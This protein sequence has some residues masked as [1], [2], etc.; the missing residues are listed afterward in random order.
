[1]TEILMVILTPQ[2]KKAMRKRASHASSVREPGVD[3]RKF[4]DNLE[5]RKT[6]MKLQLQYVNSIHTTTSLINNIQDSD[7]SLAEKITLSLNIYEK[8]V[9]FKE[10][11]SFK[12]L[13]YYWNGHIIAQCRQNNKINQI[14]HRNT[15]NQ[16]NHFTD[17]LKK[18]EVY[19][20]KTFK[21][22]ITQKKTFLSNSSNSR[23]QTPYSNIFPE[24]SP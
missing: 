2:L 23:P 24:Q 16:I 7:K 1:M 4:L 21:A 10:K 22:I 3:F 11:P 5:H 15:K 8:N 9:K 14:G 13:C 19:K 20:M 12:K 17:K 6:T 18:R